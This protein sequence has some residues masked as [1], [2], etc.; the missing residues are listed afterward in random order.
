M[1]KLRL[2]GDRLIRLPPV[3]TKA[4]YLDGFWRWVEL[5]A[6][7]DY[8]GALEVLHWPTANTTWTPEVLILV[9]PGCR[10][11]L[12]CQ[13]TSGARRKTALS[14]ARLSVRGSPVVTGLLLSPFAGA[15]PRRP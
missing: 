14:T 3:D 15:R 9:Q 2:N 6:A 11:R 8:A 1:A 7:N 12:P 4:N 5:L 13:Y 10:P